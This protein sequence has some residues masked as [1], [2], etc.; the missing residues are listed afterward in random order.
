MTSS[1]GSVGCRLSSAGQNCRREAWQMADASPKTPR[2]CSSSP[3]GPRRCEPRILGAL[4]CRAL[5]DR[6]PDRAR[7]SAQCHRRRSR[8]AA[9]VLRVGRR[10]AFAGSQVGSAVNASTVI[11]S[12]TAARDRDQAK[13]DGIASP[14]ACEGRNDI[15]ADLSAAIGVGHSASALWQAFQARGE[16]CDCRVGALTHSLGERIRPCCHRV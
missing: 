4:A 9:H 6:S 13:P 11:P 10:P 15:I 14:R 7:S 16:L 8:P 5:T 2:G 3:C 1:C 12:W